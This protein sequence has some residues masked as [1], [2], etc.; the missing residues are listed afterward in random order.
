MYFDWLAVY[1]DLIVNGVAVTL[2]LTAL[3]TVLG[4]AIGTLFAWALTWGPKTIRPPVVVYVEF[5][6]NTPFLI[7]LFFLFFGL[8][9]AGIR[10]S[11]IWAA[12]LAMILYVA[13][14]ATEIIRAGLAATPRGQ[15]EAG[16][17]LGMSRT[18]VFFHVALWPAFS[19]VWPALSSQ[20]VIA[21]LGSAVVSLISVEDLSYAT[22]FIETRNFRAF[23]TYVFSTMTYLA[24]AVLL[25]ALLAR[26]ASR[27]AAG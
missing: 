15:I 10:L 25:R 3:G 21:M 4:V 17:S 9:E 24:M 1:T 11:P 27:L 26:L 13:A 23:E 7:Q 2:R 5:V 14:Y 18:E 20:I 16:L 12:H 6:R 22:S 19:R 8:P